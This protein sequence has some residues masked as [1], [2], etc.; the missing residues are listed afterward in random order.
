[1]RKI[2]DGNVIY[3]VKE[4]ENS[5]QLRCSNCDVVKNEADITVEVDKTTGFNKYK[6]E[7]GCSTFTPQEDFSQYDEFLI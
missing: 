4:D 5:M 2:K 3:L 7:C 1:M 6:C